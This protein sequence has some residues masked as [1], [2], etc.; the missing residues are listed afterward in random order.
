MP[1]GTIIEHPAGTEG[2]GQC[3]ENSGKGE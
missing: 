1:D 2:A 3:C